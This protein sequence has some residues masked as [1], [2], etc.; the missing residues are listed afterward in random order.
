MKNDVFGQG[1]LK[2]CILVANDPLLAIPT[3]YL[4]TPPFNTCYYSLKASSRTYRY[5]SE[6]LEKN[7]RKKMQ[8]VTSLALW[9]LTSRG[10]FKD[11]K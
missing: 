2:F 5:P 8:Q 6:S 1:F 11:D 10:Q 7:A 3:T 4:A 9:M